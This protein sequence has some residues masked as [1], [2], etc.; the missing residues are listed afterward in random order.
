MVRA[1]KT[2]SMDI[3]KAK[4][5]ITQCSLSITNRAK[6]YYPA[7]RCSLKSNMGI[8]VLKDIAICSVG[9][10]LGVYNSLWRCATG[11]ISFD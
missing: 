4:Y 2:R 7:F 5:L 1:V 3:F 6:F 11:S 8:N 9:G 10:Q